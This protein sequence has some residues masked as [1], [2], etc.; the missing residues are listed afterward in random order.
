MKS[1]ILF[2]LAYASVIC[3]AGGFFTVLPIEAGEAMVLAVVSLGAVMYAGGAAASFWMAVYV[4]LA[5]AAAGAALFMLRCKRKKSFFSPALAAVSLIVVGA[6]IGFHR[7]FIQKIDD[8]HQWAAEIKYMLER[9]HLPG[10]DF[11]GSPYVYM[12]TGVFHLFF[13]LI[14]GYQEGNMYTSSVLLTAVALV[15]P[16]SFYSWKDWKKALCYVAVVYLGLFSLYQ[17]PYKSLYVDLPVAAWSGALCV[18]WVLTL[19][20]KERTDSRGKWIINGIFLLAGLIFSAFIKWGI[21]LLLTGLT[22]LYVL[23]SLAVATGKD[24]CLRTLRKMAVPLLVILAAGQGLFALGYRRYGKMLIPVDL[25]GVR[26]ALM[27]QTDKAILTRSALVRNAFY[28]TLSTFS[29]WNIASVAAVAGIVVIFLCIAYLTRG[30]YRHLMIFS[31][32]FTVAAYLL[33]MT[34][35]YITY[36]STFVYEESIS[37][38][39]VHR[40]LSTIVLYLFFLLSGL[41]FAAFNSLPVTQRGKY[42]EGGKEGYKEDCKGSYKEGCKEGSKESY[43]EDCREDG[44]KD[45]RF[46]NRG[47]ILAGIAGL[48]LVFFAGGLNRSFI[49]NASSFD[50]SY[51]RSNRIVKRAKKRLK[52]LNEVVNEDERVYL[53]AQNISLE[54][55]NEYPLCTLL[56][57]R[58]NMISNYMR[59][60][61]KFVEG[62][63]LQML[64]PCAVTIEEFPAM[65]DAGGYRYVWV[66]ETDDYLREH[67][68]AVLPCA[69]PVEKGLYRLVYDKGVLTGMEY[70]GE[71]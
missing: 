44:K 18:W 70:V 65:L 35:L 50:S 22:I 21:G 11:L 25:T 56:Y 38:A 2:L 36:V 64:S 6:S 19:Q 42:T 29:R 47:R 26:E 3:V 66:F 15:L 51:L 8:F 68:P 62:G 40:Y 69:E 54:H 30:T 67:L 13:Q 53:L 43:K 34:A 41:L 23:L 7:D 58:E 49:S 46:I 63:S 57:Y 32:V 61:W 20:K 4:Y 24:A 28:K 55:M 1:E 12:L 59:T 9:G 5:L 48:M 52:N 27:M 71:I 16:L 14:G 39:A 10:P 37:N 33:Y 60:P 31:T 17:H 45:I